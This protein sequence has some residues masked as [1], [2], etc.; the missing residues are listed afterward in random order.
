MYVISAVS[1]EGK[2]NLSMLDF[3]GNCMRDRTEWAAEEFVSKFLPKK[4]YKTPEAIDKDHMV[5]GGDRYDRVCH[6]SALVSAMDILKEQY[7]TPNVFVTAAPAKV[8]AFQSF[9]IGECKLLPISQAIKDAKSWFACKVDGM[10]YD[11]SRPGDYSPPAWF[12]KKSDVMSE[13]N[14]KVISEVVTVSTTLGT[15]KKPDKKI[16]VTIPVLINSKKLTKGTELVM[17]KASEDR[18]PTKRPFAEV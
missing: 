3:M 17:Y 16:K 14:M 18:A 13:V 4:S 10:A 1:G 2:V 12:V 7:P 5:P 8:F 15:S 11:L 6:Q 9:A